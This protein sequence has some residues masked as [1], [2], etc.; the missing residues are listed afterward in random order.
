MKMEYCKKVM[1]SE[2]SSNPGFYTEKW[3]IFSLL[4]LNLL[5]FHV[6]I[7]AGIWVDPYREKVLGTQPTNL[8]AYW[9][10]NE[11]SGSVASNCQGIAARNGTYKNVTLGEPGIGDGWTCPYFTNACVNIYSAS[12]NSSYNPIEGTVMAWVKV[13]P[14]AWT[15]GANR[16]AVCL[17]TSSDLVQVDIGKYSGTDRFKWFYRQ[18]PGNY[19]RIYKTTSETNW[20]CVAATWSY[21]SGEWIGYWD[22]SEDATRSGVTNTVGN[23]VANNTAIGAY[24]SSDCAI[25]WHG[26][27]AHVAIWN[28]PLTGPEIAELA[29]VEERYEII[30]GTAIYIK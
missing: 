23:L 19:S 20:V 30:P 21:S 3:L 10:L 26:W 27:I 15:D 14:A 16:T 29:V 8:I 18:I 11:T 22:G 7:Y 25:P 5:C 12:L 6:P 24:R 9:P 2:I 4:L 17:D 13:T 28:T 1:M